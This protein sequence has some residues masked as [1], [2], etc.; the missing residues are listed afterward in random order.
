MVIRVADCETS[1]VRFRAKKQSVYY[2]KHP[3]SHHEPDDLTTEAE[4]EG[5][6]N[7]NCEQIDSHVYADGGLI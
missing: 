2:I 1:Q 7:I 5:V 4:G 6:A 3:S